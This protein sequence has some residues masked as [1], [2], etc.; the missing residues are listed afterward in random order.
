M[1]TSAGNVNAT[2]LGA[3]SIG[4]FV[5]R[6]VGKTRV[7]GQVEYQLETVGRFPLGS[8]GEGNVFTQWDFTVGGAP[9]PPGFYQVTVRAVE[10]DVVRELGKPQGLWIDVQ[11]R[12]HM[13]GEDSEVNAIRRFAHPG[14]RG[15]AGGARVLRV[16]ARTSS[17]PPASPILRGR[18]R[19]SRS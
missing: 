8:F 1:I 14:S 9:L 16:R 19:T 12:P 4:I 13:I 5:Q 15:R 18:V 2:L 10:G 11:G 17:R 6:I 3:S 7:L